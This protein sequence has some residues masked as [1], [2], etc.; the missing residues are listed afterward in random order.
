MSN[1]FIYTIYIRSMPEKVW[2]AITNP[3]FTRQYWGDP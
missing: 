2:A 1:D 3:E